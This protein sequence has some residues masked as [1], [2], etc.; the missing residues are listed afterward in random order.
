MDNKPSKISFDKLVEDFG[1]DKAPNDALA[2]RGDRMGM[3]ADAQDR[4]P[5]REPVQPREQTQIAQISIRGPS[6]II[7]RFKRICADDR[8][9]YYD[10]LEI[11]MNH[12]ERGQ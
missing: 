2:S 9:H 6:H 7:E 8:R 11:M 10:M 5:S 3:A 4:W 12:F 1:D